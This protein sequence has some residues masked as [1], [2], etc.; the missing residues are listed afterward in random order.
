MTVLPSCLAPLIIPHMDPFYCWTVVRLTSKYWRS[1]IEQFFRSRARLQYT[2]TRGSV[3]ISDVAKY[4]ER[5]PEMRFYLEIADFNT[6]NQ[7]TL[8]LKWI[9]TYSNSCDIYE[10]DEDWSIFVTEQQATSI[11][12]GNAFIEAAVKEYQANTIWNVVVTVKN[13]KTLL[14][15]TCEICFNQA[16]GHPFHPL[17]LCLWCNHTLTD[18]TWCS[19][20]CKEEGEYYAIPL[21]YRNRS[22]ADIERYLTRLGPGYK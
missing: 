20:A 9:T 17:Q 21:E 13:W 15:S 10:R 4:D 12:D 19:D 18:E 1:E 11:W 16:F 7:P 22:K 14:G 2:T 5:S 8:R 6:W 3:K